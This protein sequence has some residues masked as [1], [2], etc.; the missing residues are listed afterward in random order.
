M[1]H[2][3]SDALKAALSDLYSD[4]RGRIDGDGRLSPFKV[5]IYIEDENS[6]QT[7]ADYFFENYGYSAQLELSAFERTA[8]GEDP[9]TGGE[10]YKAGLMPIAVGTAVDY[11]LVGFA[12]YN[13]IDEYD[14]ETYVNI[15][16]MPLSTPSF[17]PGGGDESDIYTV[18]AGLVDQDGELTLE[19]NSH[20]TYSLKLMKQCYDGLLEGSQP[21]LMWLH[22]DRWSSANWD[23]NTE[24]DGEIYKKIDADLK[25][26]RGKIIPIIDGTER[27]LGR[28]SQ[29]GF[30]I[31]ENYEIGET[32]G[33]CTV[34]G[35]AI[36]IEL[37]HEMRQMLISEDDGNLLTLDEY[38]RFFVGDAGEDEDPKPYLGPFYGTSSTAA[39]TATKDVT[40]ADFTVDSLLPGAIITVKFTNANTAA[41]PT[42]N[43]NGTG[44]KPIVT[45]YGTAVEA[46]DKGPIKANAVLVFAYDGTNWV[47]QLTPS[48][49]FLNIMTVTTNTTVSIAHNCMHLVCDN[50]S[51]ITITLPQMATVGFQFTVERWGSGNVTIVPASGVTIN[52]ASNNITLG[53]QYTSA[54]SV[55][56][57]MANTYSVKG[58]MA[59]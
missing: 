5:S 42:L 41:N 14:G 31:V 43:V 3:T 47:V 10:L 27:L 40:C 34:T 22:A 24:V 28:I 48:G 6:T 12:I 8:G 7:A 54:V 57:I 33:D 37:S 59:S 13:S 55:V 26:V 1:K 4:L 45:P 32:L 56:T 21:R 53:D 36:P 15:Q 51:D 44:A 2:V 19:Y 25:S 35:I 50:S 46:G 29:T 16:I 17:I 39:A 49:E 52:G 9:L 23:D 20:S 58:G 18:V 30:F 11:G 38:G